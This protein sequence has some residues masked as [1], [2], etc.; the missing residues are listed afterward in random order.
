M[1]SRFDD[2]NDPKT[3]ER[4]KLD[5]SERERHAEVYALHRDLLK[6]RRTDPVFN[7]Q[8]RGSFDGA[9]LSPHAFILRF[10]GERAN[11]RLILFNFGLDLH[12][13][14]AP[15]P[16]LAP[17]EG[18]LWEMLFSTEDPAYGGSGTPPLE[19]EKNWR[20]PGYAAVVMKPE[21]R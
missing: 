8:R 18:K 10:F 21:A 12:L 4:S 11:D 3:F 7:S 19:T 16:L 5:H 13:N 1:A 17:P 6:L 14:P 15:E 20:I 2:P 9:V